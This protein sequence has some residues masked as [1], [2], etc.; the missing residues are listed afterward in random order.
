MGIAPPMAEASAA[1]TILFPLPTFFTG[2]QRSDVGEHGRSHP[3]AEASAATTI[4]EM[5]VVRRIVVAAL[6]SAMG[7]G[8]G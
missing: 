4:H 5:P 8:C 1:T 6:A 3:M 2:T 7:W